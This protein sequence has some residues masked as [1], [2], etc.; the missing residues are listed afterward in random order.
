[1][2]GTLSLVDERKLSVGA[3]VL[4]SLRKQ[5]LE[6][7]GE[8]EPGAE[9]GTESGNR[10]PHLTQGGAAASCSIAMIQFVPVPLG[11]ILCSV[12]NVQFTYDRYIQFHC[13]CAFEYDMIF[14]I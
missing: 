12:S 3:E 7:G 2:I 5:Y 8:R 13:V 11:P 14:R 10:P 9:V 6:L 4:L 1:V